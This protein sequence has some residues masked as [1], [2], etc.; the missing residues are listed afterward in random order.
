MENRD[1]RTIQMVGEAG[2]AKLKEAKVLIVGVG[3]VGSYAAEAISRAGVGTVT[4]MDGDQ[5][6]ASNLNRQLVAL[7]S[8]IGKNKALVMAERIKD[9]NPECNASGMAAFYP[10]KNLDISSYDWIIDAIDDVDA[11]VALIKNAQAAGVNIIS[12]MGAAG[13]FETYFKAADISKTN[14]CPLAKVM[15]KR[16]RAEGIEHLPVVFSE[17]KPIPRDGELGS[18]PYVPGAMGLELAGYVIKEIVK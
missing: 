15:R 14:M 18:M 4:V 17:E 11:K 2:M 16:L 8:T 5:V 9:I 3:G 7:A 10:D 12:A 1:A 13:K 6:A